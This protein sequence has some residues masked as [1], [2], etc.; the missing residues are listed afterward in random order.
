[1]KSEGKLSE[2]EIKYEPY[3]NTS[4]KSEIV[5]ILCEGEEIN[6]AG[7]GDTVEIV[8]PETCFYIESGGQVSDSGL[9]HSQI[10]DEWEI[11]VNEVIKPTAGMILHIGEVIKGNPKVGDKV[12]VEVDAKRRRDVMRNHTATHLLHA[13][14]RKVIGVHVRQAGS[15]VAPERLRFDFTQNEPISEIDLEKVEEGV[16]QAILSNYPV[17]LEV[18]PL[19]KATAEGATALFGEKYGESVRTISIMGES[20]ISYELCGGTH[21]N[22]TGDIGS[23]IILSESSVAAGI[24]RIEAVTGVQAYEVIRQR[25]KIL[26]QISSKLSIPME[27]A[28]DRVRSLI[29]ENEKQMK[30]IGKLHEG[31]A[32]IE[33]ENNKTKDLQKIGQTLVYITTIGSIETESL[34][35]LADKFKLQN[36]SSVLAIGT[37]DLNSEKATLLISISDDLV[38][39]KGLNAV[40]LVKEAGVLINGGGGGKPTLAQAG[41]NNS[42]NLPLALQKI[43]ELITSKL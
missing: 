25:M 30:E 22:Q 38:K 43:R 41:G 33:F 2:D 42:S 7:P 32:E 5:T 23:F 19:A 40:E 12:I 36:P 20:R 9:I 3:S 11:R 1:L 18:K 39:N 8:L 17:T 31:L 15:L 28:F 13:E 10:K 6:Q 27:N 24:R 4:I 29:A 37:K 16:N 35:K 14:L 34:R 21:V 26:G